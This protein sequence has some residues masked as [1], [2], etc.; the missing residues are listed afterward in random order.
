MEFEKLELVSVAAV[1]ELR[2]T[3]LTELFA[4]ISDLREGIAAYEAGEW[5]KSAELFLKV[6]RYS[7]NAFSGHLQ[8]PLSLY[9]APNFLHE[10]LNQGEAALHTICWL[11]MYALHDAATAYFQAPDGTYNAG[12][13]KRAPSTYGRSNFG[14][15]TDEAVRVG[16]DLKTAGVPIT[17]VL[18]IRDT[19]GQLLDRSE[20]YKDAA[21]NI[22]LLCLRCLR[23]T[24]VSTS[25]IL[26]IMFQE[27]S[28]D[29]INS[30][31]PLIII[32]TIR[33]RTWVDR[34]V[35]KTLEMAAE[36]SSGKDAAWKRLSEDM[37][38]S[39]TCDPSSVMLQ[40]PYS[41]QTDFAL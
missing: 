32:S 25:N 28:L 7:E 4:P 23:M 8:K 9:D 10:E 35:L 36:K 26:S 29:R 14:P 30:N 34:A 6:W 27:S 15:V 38:R 22:S 39:A 5:V 12:D 18:H 1:K 40:K 19:V 33:W 11:G 13:I 21:H 17:S 2:R 3:N 31:L 37:L 20:T 24:Q 41:F 16:G